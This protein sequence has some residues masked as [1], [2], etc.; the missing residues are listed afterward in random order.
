M[1]SMGFSLYC[2]STLGEKVD[3]TVEIRKFDDSVEIHKSLT[4]II[5]TWS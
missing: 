3:D 5:T 4:L 1:V 2:P